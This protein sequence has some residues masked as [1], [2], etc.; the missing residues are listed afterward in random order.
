KPEAAHEVFANRYGDCKGMA[1]LTKAKLKVAGF[2]ARLTWIGTNRILYTYEIPTMA[3]D[4]HMICTEYI[5]D[6]H[7]ILDPT[8]KYIALGHHAERIQGKEMLIEDGPGYVV[9][10]VPVEDPK[11]N[12]VLRSETLSIDGDL[13]RGEGQVN[14][15]GE[16]KTQIL[17]HA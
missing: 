3:A 7:Y 5:G 2:D 13:L 17:Y 1:N 6:K 10:K 16:S 11:R 14:Y 9:S 8:E 4:N 15:N 12:L